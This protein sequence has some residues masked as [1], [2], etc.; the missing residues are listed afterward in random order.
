MQT[1]S[2]RTPFVLALSAALALAA[3]GVNAAGCPLQPTAAAPAV[4]VPAD[5]LRTF[6]ERALLIELALRAGRISPYDAGRLLRE[7][8]ELARFRQGLLAY[9]QTIPAQG[10]GSACLGIDLVDKLAPLGDMARGGLRSAGGLMRALLREAERLMQD[11]VPSGH[12]PM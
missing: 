6:Q 9:A 2:S 11:T 5:P 7:Q 8:W 12:A 4:V 3:A 10:T 1:R